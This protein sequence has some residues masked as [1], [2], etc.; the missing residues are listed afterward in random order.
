MTDFDVIIIGA[1]AAGL[2][3]AIEA[4]KRGRRVLVM[5]S[6]ETIAGKIRI[7]GG[8]RCNFTNK[9]TGAANFLS[10]NPRFCLSALKRYRP[11]NFIK[12]VEKY[13]IAYHEKKLGQLFCDGK[14]HQII[15]M[16]LKECEIAGVI[17]RTSQT[18]EDVEKQDD[19]YRLLTAYETLTCQALVI[20]SGGKSI[21]KMGATGFGYDLARQFDHTIIK[22]EPA[23]V[24]FTFQN[25]QLEKL[26]SLAGVSTD[27][28]VSLGKK[29][30]A[31][32]IL[33]T[34][35]G[36][37]GPAILQI[38]TYWKTGDEVCINM[39]PNRDMMEFLKEQR[40]SQP[41]QEIHNVL[42]QRFARRLA[43]FICDEVGVDGR[44][45]DLSNK[46]L[47][48]VA[49]LIHNWRIKPNGTEGFRTAEVTRGGIDTREISSK[50]FESNKAEGLYFIGE[51]LDVT[52][53]LGGY[54]FQWA[55][56]SGHAAGQYV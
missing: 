22:P 15:D 5:E 43:Q 44:L 30:F 54:N 52:G 55:W 19:G 4:G 51:V 13:D 45:A 20:A 42:T 38:S 40:V 14:S 25:L 1:G 17:V 56:A 12:L 11:Q 10:E 23:L 9:N 41:K 18:V 16:L 33:F 48:L 26:K 8:G 29:S 7:S 27:A 31:E 39:S 32:A 35:R 28:V 47:E 6:A 53:Q 50:T 24:P 49:D 2:M 3:C 46:K 34:H 21:P 37:S 36:L